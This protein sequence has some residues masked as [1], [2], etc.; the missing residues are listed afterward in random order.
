MSFD[1]T[2]FKKLERAGYNR[3]GA[4]YLAASAA[5]QSIADTLLAAAG[6]EPGQRLLDLASGPGLLAQEARKTL[7][8]DGLAVASDISEGQLACC[9][10]LLRVAADGEALPFAARSFQRVLCGLGLMFFP[11]EQAAL[12]EMRRV[13]TPDGRL[14]LSVWG[15]ASEVPLVETALA[16]MRRVLPPPKVVRPSIFRFGDADELARRLASADFSGIEIRPFRFAVNFR[17]AA[18]YWQGFLDLAGGAAESLSRL[19]ADKQQE[20]A[21]AV[22]EELAPHAVAGGYRLTSTILVATA[23]PV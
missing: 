17:D 19:P 10:D 20:L 3:L 6:L 13:L 11:D 8:S 5:R 12:R 23:G 2:Q 7:G 22:G 14:A 4:R 15:A 18:G 1:S 16:C 21:G 9:P